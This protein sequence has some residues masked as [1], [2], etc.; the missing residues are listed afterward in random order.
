MVAVVRRV[1][2]AGGRSVPDGVMVRA[3]HLS[4]NIVSGVGSV[5]ASSI[6]CS[7]MTC[8]GSGLPPDP[9]PENPLFTVTEDEY[10]GF[11]LLVIDSLPDYVPPTPHMTYRGYG[12]THETVAVYTEHGCLDAPVQ[13]CD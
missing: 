11:P 4:N 12:Y 13:E 2:V 6:T 8:R 3:D 9:L 1:L 7:T 10:R 5:N